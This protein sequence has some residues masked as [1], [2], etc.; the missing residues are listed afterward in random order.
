VAQAYYGNLLSRL[1]AKT[2]FESQWVLPVPPPRLVV[3]WL[4][5]RERRLRVDT[6]AIGIDRPVFILS[7]PRSGSSMLQDILCAH[8]DAAY[9]TN[10]MYHFPTCLCAA[11]RFRREAALH[12]RGERYLA[13]SVMVESGSPS[14]PVETWCNWLGNDP[15]DL[16]FRDLRLADLAPAAVERIRS[17]IRRVLWCFGPGSHRFVCKTP[18]LLPY[19]LLLGELFPDGRFIHLVRDPRPNANSMLKL[20]RLTEEQRLRIRRR[21]GRRARLD[22]MLI[23]YPRLPRLREYVERFGPD[24]IRTPAHLWDDAARFM[25]ERRGRLPSWHEVRYEDIVARPR[26]TLEGM[27]DFCGFDRPPADS[28]LWERVGQVGQVSHTNEYGG[29]EEVAAICRETMPWHGYA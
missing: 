22:R 25:A 21:H 18:A 8:P 4:R 29:F 20:H 3:A 11:E 19:C 2:G 9:I 12:V 13:D 27:L 28:P 24:D 26:E 14:D 5:W 1:M 10:M 6:S 16:A 17:D 7:L 15:Y 23:P